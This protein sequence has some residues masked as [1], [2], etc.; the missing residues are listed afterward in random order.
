MPEPTLRIFFREPTVDTNRPIT[1]GRVGIEGF[2]VE[3]VGEL[4]DAD[5]WDCGFAARMVGAAKGARYVSIPAFPNRK[6][7]LSYIYVNAEAGIESPGDLEGKRVGIPL[8][9][10]TAGVWARGA[11]QHYYGVD[12]ARIDWVMARP[13]KIAL[14]GYVKSDVLNRGDLNSLLVSGEI[15]AVIEP[16]VLP[17]V[18]NRDP[19]VRRLFADYKSEEKTYF[20][21]TGIFPISHVVTLKEEFVERHPEA[22]V[23]LL[24]AFRKARDIA[25]DN[26][27]GADPQVLIVAWHAALMDEQRELM[28]DDYF[29]YNIENN[30]VALEAM[31]QY[32]QEQGL[33]SDRV[34]YRGLF[35]PEA[36]QLPG[37]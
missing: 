32:A 27:Q 1:E 4:D 30:T 15:D 34:D 14:P 20:S 33:T 2:S 35:S 18:T 5:A 26:V 19:R 28:G 16:N 23:A 31:T 37:V 25:I 22:P 6:F 36:A 17:A 7:R 12:L 9:A 3:V 8:W 10:N 11:L 13:E 21:A 24:K 29:S